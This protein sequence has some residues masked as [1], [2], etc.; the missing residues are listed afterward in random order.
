[1]GGTASEYVSVTLSE[2]KAVF[3]SSAFL[4]SFLLSFLSL[5]FLLIVRN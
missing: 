3:I 2:G 1:M 4:L 5:V